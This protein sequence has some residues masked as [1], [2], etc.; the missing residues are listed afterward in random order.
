ME[1]R[2]GKI[3]VYGESASH[4]YVCIQSDQDNWPTIRS[5]TAVHGRS[6]NV[7]LQ[8][9]SNMLRQSAESFDD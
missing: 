5:L 7:R 6:Q 3:V 4:I 8:L 2:P 1:Y 9:H